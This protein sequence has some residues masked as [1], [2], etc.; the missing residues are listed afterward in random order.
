MKR[1]LPYLNLSQ[2][3]PDSDFKK[4]FAPHAS[5]ALP[6]L[7]AVLGS[8]LKLE[9]NSDGKFTFTQALKAIKE[10]FSDGV[11]VDHCTLGLNDAKGILAILTCS[12][13][14]NLLY[15]AQTSPQG[16]RWAASVPI[17]PSIFKQHRNIPYSDWDWTDKNKSF[18]LDQYFCDYSDNFYKPTEYSREELL[19]IRETALIVKS[20]SK[21]GTRRKIESCTS[22]YGHRDPT[23][24]S[25]PKLLQLSLCQLWIFY[26]P[27][28]HEYMITNHMDLDSPSI[29]LVDG[30]VFEAS[31]PPFKVNKGIVWDEIH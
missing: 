12:P 8:E 15:N 10:A 29:P 9:R 18:L 1:T 20:G 27:F 3:E 4:L 6:Q 2:F 31:P 14:G 22:V 24:A 16:I 19:E 21:E 26:T 25:L 5:W 13:R 7:A 28:R 17:F 23:F 11:L 30:E